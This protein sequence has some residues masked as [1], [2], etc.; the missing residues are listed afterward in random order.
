M[1]ACVRVTSSRRRRLYCVRAPARTDDTR[2][3]TQKRYE[4]SRRRAVAFG[5]PTVRTTRAGRRNRRRRAFRRTRIVCT[6][7][8]EYSIIFVVA[9]MHA[10]GSSD[11]AA[12]RAHTSRPEDVASARL[13]IYSRGDALSGPSGGG[14][15]RGVGGARQRRPYALDETI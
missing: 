3:R 13:L 4:I 14:G 2:A 9:A 7:S 15:W 10:S 8:F 1:C 6:R 5:F 12:P 11:D